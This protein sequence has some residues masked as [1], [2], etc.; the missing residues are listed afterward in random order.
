MHII[1]N[2]HF[3]QW[4]PTPIPGGCPGLFSG[5]DVERSVQGF[6]HEYRQAYF[7]IILASCQPHP[8]PRMC[9]RYMDPCHLRAATS[10]TLHAGTDPAQTT[11]PTIF[12]PLTFPSVLLPPTLAFSPVSWLTGSHGCGSNDGERTAV[13]IDGPNHLGGLCAECDGDLQSIHVQDEKSRGSSR[14]RRFS[15]LSTN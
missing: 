5:W 3:N 1:I 7:D 12:A 14:R 13:Q 15:Q 9:V 10:H 2:S 8:D 4:V 11:T 6:L